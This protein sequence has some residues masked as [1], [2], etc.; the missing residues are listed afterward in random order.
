M[1]R[2]GPTHESNSHAQS[3]VRAAST[4]IALLFVLLACLGL[5]ACGSSESPS[6]LAATKAYKQQRAELMDLVA[7]GR[8]HGIAM[9]APT[10]DNKLD[11][12]GVNVSSPRRKAAL[13]NCYHKAVRTAAAEHEAE[14][15]QKER[16]E[17]PA[18]KEAAAAQ[19]AATFKQERKQLIE[20]VSCVRQHGIHM[21]E[22]D[23]H[24]N[25]NTRGLHLRSHHNNIVVTGCL[26]KVV[27]KATGEQQ[28]Q[29]QE[30]GP[31]QIGE[32]PAG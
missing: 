30:Q 31:V 29:G 7:C 6:A 28:E 24:N 16:R 21:P 23:A 11:M 3:D 8:Q 5:A 12:H 1:P 22:P 18:E 4:T 25:I 20:L 15:A 32:T 13:N 19:K 27:G 17:G 26:H 2:R 14:Q 10:P 9:P